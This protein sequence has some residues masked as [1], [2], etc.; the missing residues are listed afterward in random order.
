MSRRAHA[1]LAAALA[2]ALVALHLDFW[3]P[4]RDELWLGWIPEELAWRLGW[5]GL[6]LLY[7]FYFC[8]K[9]WEDE[10]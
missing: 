2:V 9:V 10:E 5:M 8:A 4:R 7:L 3:R 6:A 1:R